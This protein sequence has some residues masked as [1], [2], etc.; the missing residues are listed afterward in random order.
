MKKIILS[1][2]L[3]SNSFAEE[4]RWVFQDGWRF[5]KEDSSAG[6]AIIQKKANTIANNYYRNDHLLREILIDPY[7]TSSFQKIEIGE[8]FGQKVYFDPRI[9]PTECLRRRMENNGIGNH[10]PEPTTNSLLIL[11]GIILFFIRNL[12]KISV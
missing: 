4:G 7:K 12:K 2:F 6:G 3:I 5:V 11:S 1:L 8:V 9:R 10:T